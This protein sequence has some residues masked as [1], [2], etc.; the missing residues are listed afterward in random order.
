MDKKFALHACFVF[1]FVVLLF[2]G[3]SAQSFRGGMKGGLT[4]S[5][6]SG[7]RSAGPNKLGWFASVFTD[8]PLSEYTFWHL[9]LMYIRKGSREFNDPDDPSQGLY[10][11]Y[12]FSLQYV[13]IPVLVKMQFPVAGHGAYFT[14]FGGEFGL[15]ASRVIGHSE[16]DFDNEISE[17]ISETRPFRPAELNLILGIT[18]P[19][20]ELLA[21]SLRLDQ[22]LTPIRDHA[23]GKKVWY[24]HG[25]Y[26]TAWSLGLSLTIF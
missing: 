3:M 16:T 25:Q 7:D 22:G 1:V 18:I 6:V 21:F 26:N 4:A 9:E 2:H 14:W 17:E 11:D 19:V 13:E 10:R 5:E 20:G 23:S 24:N 12:K 15:S 8:Y